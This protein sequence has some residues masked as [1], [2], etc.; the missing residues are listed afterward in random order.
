MDLQQR[1]IDELASWLSNAE[2]KIEANDT[3]G[4]D[5]ETIKRQIEDHKVNRIFRPSLHGEYHN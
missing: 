1:Q 2:A 4:S 5:L 3:V